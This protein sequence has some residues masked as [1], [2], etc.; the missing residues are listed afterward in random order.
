MFDPRFET[1]DVI[2]TFANRFLEGAFPIDPNLGLAM[3]GA[4]STFYMQ[5]G[6]CL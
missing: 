5:E 6:L 1:D 4:Q 2:Q 3:S